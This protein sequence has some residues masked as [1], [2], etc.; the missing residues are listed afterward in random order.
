M[1]RK[2]ISKD[3]HRMFLEDWAK[4]KEKGWTQIKISE[5]LG[6]SQPAFNQYLKGKVALNAQFLLSYSHARKIDPAVIGINYFKKASVRAV[7]LPL[8]FSVSG[9]NIKGKTVVIDNYAGDTQEAFLVDVDTTIPLV[10]IGGYIVCQPHPCADS[11]NVFALNSAGE[12]HVGRLLKI[13][14]NWVLSSLQ[15]S[16][17]I[18]L[19]KK[20]WTLYK[21]TGTIAP[22]SESTETF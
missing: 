5:A 18:P 10:G 2:L 8:Q 4:A 15:S 14:D 12:T 7:T 9:K 1:E 22:A 13:N 16:I 11:D 6:M 3:A 19:T 17:E 21:I 20:E